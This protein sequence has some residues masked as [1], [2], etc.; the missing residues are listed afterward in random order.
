M[1]FWSVPLCAVQKP[2]WNLD[3]IPQKCS[4]FKP[5]VLFLVDY[6]WA[7]QSLAQDFYT[8]NIPSSSSVLCI[9]FLLPLLPASPSHH[10]AG[11]DIPFSWRVVMT[12]RALRMVS[13]AAVSLWRVR[14]VPL[15]LQVRNGRQGCSHSLCSWSARDSWGLPSYWRKGMENK[16]FSTV[17]VAVHVVLPTYYLSGMNV[18]THSVS[19]A[20][21]LG[22]VSP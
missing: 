21:E 8:E 12:D 20:E 16:S 10:L 6:S 7:V 15:L 11:R 13:A 3:Q 17:S 19:R 2:S 9:A 22:P 5:F 18:R 4:V 14:D 1:L